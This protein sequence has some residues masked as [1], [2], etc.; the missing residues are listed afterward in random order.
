MM[1]S[2][3]IYID[4]ITINPQMIK[5]HNFEIFSGFINLTTHFCNSIKCYINTLSYLH[6][7]LTMKKS[8]I[9]INLCFNKSGHTSKRLKVELRNL[10][11]SKKFRPKAQTIQK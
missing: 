1:P 3:Q 11:K 5:K 7:T 8:L 6:G 2:L 4:S 9:F 10:W